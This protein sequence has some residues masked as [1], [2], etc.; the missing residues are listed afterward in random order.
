MF[1]KINYSNVL[2]K[3]FGPTQKNSLVKKKNAK[4][5]SLPNIIFTKF[6]KLKSKISLKKKI[7]FLCGN[8]KYWFLNYLAYQ[9]TWFIVKSSVYYMRSQHPGLTYFQSK[10]SSSLLCLLKYL[11]KKSYKLYNLFFYFLKLKRN[12][13]FDKSFSHNSSNLTAALPS[14]SLI[15][16]FLKNFHSFY[17]EES[18]LLEKFFTPYR[19]ALQF[20]NSFFNFKIRIVK[21][22]KKRNLKRKK[23]IKQ[24]NFNFYVKNVKKVFIYTFSTPNLKKKKKLFN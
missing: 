7:N 13:T 18:L 6:T 15:N 1:S 10:K 20:F 9:K 12:K 2:H 3:L 19:N 21:V 14:F 22:E 17:F 23:N 4:N 11:Q 8:Q 16:G 5:F 24:I